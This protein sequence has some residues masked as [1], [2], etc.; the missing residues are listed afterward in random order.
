MSGN[1]EAMAAA[2]EAAFEAEARRKGFVR[3]RWIPTSERMPEPTRW[4]GEVLALNDR[5]ER[6]ALGYRLV[7]GRSPRW[8][9]GAR[10]YRGVVTH[11]MPMPEPPPGFEAA[12]R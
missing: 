3:Q 11:W 4:G 8:E 5:G 1:Q 2:H 12:T 9:E 6:L 7:E 10:V